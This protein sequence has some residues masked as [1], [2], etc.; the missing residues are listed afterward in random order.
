MVACQ[1]EVWAIYRQ[2]LALVKRARSRW[3]YFVSYDED[4]Q[5][6]KEKWNI[7]YRERNGEKTRIIMWDM[8]GIPAF[9]FGAAELQRNTFSKYYAGN[10]FKGGIGIQ[11]CSWGL[12]WTLWGGHVS[13]SEYN[14][15]AG[16][17]EAQEEFQKKDLVQQGTDP[18]SAPKVLPFTNV[19]DKGYRARA[20]NY[21][22]G[23]QLTAQPVFG[24]SDQQFKGS[25]TKFSAAVASD[26]GGNERGVNVSKRSGIIKRGFQANM[27]ASTFDD[28]WL[29]WGF[30]ANFMY[31]PIL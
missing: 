1:K 3:G 24:R 6:R 30:M 8:T 23:E 16:Y 29:C 5:L 9:K 7:K 26:R 22:H 19:L 13:D 17:L 11:L 10:C 4:V 15:K 20:T 31:R 25:E 18:T 14:E 2:K 27:D 21:S 12:T 28:A